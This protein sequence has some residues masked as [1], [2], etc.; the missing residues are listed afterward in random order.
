MAL[1]DTTYFVSD[2]RAIPGVNESANPAGVAVAAS[3]TQFIAMYEPKFLRYLFGD[4]LYDDYITNGSEARW[5]AVKA[6]LYNNT[7]KVSILAD[8][9][10][11]NWAQQHQVIATSGGD[12]ESG[13]AGMTPMANVPLYMETWRRISEGVSDVVEYLAEHPDDFPLFDGGASAEFYFE[14]VNPFDI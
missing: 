11:Y 7:T 1:I 13:D 6:L 3:V 8:Y 12:K 5:T 14:M 2:P 10:F 4:D 9:V